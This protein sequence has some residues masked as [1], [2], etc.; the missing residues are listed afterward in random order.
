MTGVLTEA[1]RPDHFSYAFLQNQDRHVHLHV[2]PRYAALRAF[3]GTTFQDPDYPSH[4]AVPALSHHL[5]AEQ[6][7]QL[8]EYF[9]ELLG[10]PTVATRIAPAI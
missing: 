5:T 6:F 10:D 8:S 9:R 2:V 7:A 3:A 4:Y 1:F